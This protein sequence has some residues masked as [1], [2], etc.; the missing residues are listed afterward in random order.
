MTATKSRPKLAPQTSKLQKSALQ[1]L[2]KCPSGIQGL[3][4]ITAG[5]LPRGR[6]TLVCGG[7]GSGKMLLGMEFLVR[8]ALDYDEPGLFVCFEETPPELTRNVASLGFD[9]DALIEQKKLLID[10]VFVERSEIEETGEFNLEGLFIRLADGIQTIGAK[11]V[12]LD[13]IEALFSGFENEAILRAELRRL[14]RWLKEQKVTAVI[15]GER[16]E[17]T[18]TRYGLEEYVA[19]CVILLDNRVTEQLTTRRLRIVKYRGSLHGANEYPFIIDEH[20]FSVAPITSVRLDYEVSSERISSGIPRLDALVGGEGYYRG[21][22]VLVSGTAGGGKTSLAA[23]CAA[24]ACERGERALYFA[25]EEPPAQIIRNMHSIGLDLQH[26]RKKGLLEFCSQRPT[27]CGLETHLAMMVKAIT[28]SAPQVVVLDPV[29]NFVSVANPQDVKAMLIRLIDFMKAR[30]I[31]AVLTSLAH[32]GKAIEGTVEG[33]SSL[34]DTWIL[35]HSVETNGERNRALYVL[36][37][38]G[39]AHSNQVRECLFSVRGVDLADVYVGPGGVMMGSSRLTQVARETAAALSEREELDCKRRERHRKRDALDARLAALRA[40][41]EAEQEEI[42]FAI[43]EAERRAAVLEA[44]RR[45]MGRFRKADVVAAGDG[46]G[47]H[48]RRKGAAQ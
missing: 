9:L 41:F 42:N 26:W 48:S 21:S 45:E 1:P 28:A 31:T 5:G 36:K 24:A 30:G 46:A 25:F 7:A 12:V 20:G 40:E 18:L 19:D 38:R 8:G 29:S 6:P 47:K 39:T 16:G 2:P 37:A 32:G 35:I 4:E 13:S 34:M 11:R 17:A 23:L 14:F 44:S 10:H 43:A 3:D 33:I 27:L 15:T 22:T